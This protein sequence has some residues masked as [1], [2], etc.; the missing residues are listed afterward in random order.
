MIVRVGD[1]PTTTTPA[2]APIPAFVA[3]SRVAEYQLMAEES[4]AAVHAAQIDA[5][6]Q[7]AAMRQHAATQIKRVSFELSHA[8]G[9]SLRAGRQGR[10]LAV[11]RTRHVA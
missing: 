9:V 6:A 11:P 7:I 1:D 3:R 2:G 8:L 4:R 10:A 5:E